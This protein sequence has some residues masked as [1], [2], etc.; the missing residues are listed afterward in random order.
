MFLFKRGQK[1][2]IEFFDEAKKQTRRLSAHTT[3]ESEAYRFLSDLEN[4][5]S[6]EPKLEET[7]SLQE[8]ADKYISY[9]QSTHSGKYARDA[10]SGFRIPTMTISRGG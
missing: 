9:L 10:K 1:W 8:F 4:R 5:L 7:I 6:E 3:K 2:Y